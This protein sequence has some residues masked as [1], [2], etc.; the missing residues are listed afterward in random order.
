MESVR[1]R[2]APIAMT[3]CEPEF[4]SQGVPAVSTADQRL[5]NRVNLQGQSSGRV[6]VKERKDAADSECG[7]KKY[8]V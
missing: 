3:L 8:R 5:R 2:N 1:K 4:A 7:F 6:L